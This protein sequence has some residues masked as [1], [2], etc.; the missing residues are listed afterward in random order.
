MVTIWIE[1]HV[2]FLITNILQAPKDVN[3]ILWRPRVILIQLEIKFSNVSEM[4]REFHIIDLKRFPLLLRLL[5]FG[6]N[7]A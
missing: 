2:L 5:S 6:V 1:L 4:E 7:M 3:S